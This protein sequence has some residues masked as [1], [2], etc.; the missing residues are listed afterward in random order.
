MR[1]GW[2]SNRHQSLPRLPPSTWCAEVP[3]PQTKPL[4]KRR[5]TIMIPSLSSVRPDSHARR[6]RR[7]VEYPRPHGARILMNAGRAAAAARVGARYPDGWRT[8]V[9]DDWLEGWSPTT[10][11]LGDGTTEV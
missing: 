9:P 3:A 5:A 1:P 6:S 4:G 2:D 10:F 7:A 11:D 8:H